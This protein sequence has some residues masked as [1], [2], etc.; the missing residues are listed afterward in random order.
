MKSRAGRAE[1]VGEAV[2]PS[3]IQA[4]ADALHGEGFA[5]WMYLDKEKLLT[6]GRG[7]LI[8]TSVAGAT[9]PMTLAWV[10]SSGNAASPDLV[11]AAINAV[12]ARPDLVPYGGAGKSPSGESFAGLT[13]VRLT[14]ATVA[15]L[16]GSSASQLASALQNYL[17]NFNAFPADAQL[18]ILRY[19]WAN[20]P[21]LPVKAPLM[22]AALG[23]RAG[24]LPDFRAAAKE[25]HW[26]NENADT[27]ALIPQLFQNAADVVDHS[28]DVSTLVWPNS[29]VQ[30]PDGVVSSTNPTTF[31]GDPI[32]WRG[33]TSYISHA[34]RFGEDILGNHT[35]A[36]VTDLTNNYGVW[37]PQLRSRFDAIKAAWAKQ[38]TS[39]WV[40][41]DAGTAASFETDLKG[42]E[43]RW[44]LAQ[45]L[46]SVDKAADWNVGILAAPLL[47]VPA[48]LE[49]FYTKVHGGTFADIVPAETVYQA[50]LSAVAQDPNHQGYTTGDYADLDRRLSAEEAT[51]GVQTPPLAVVQPHAQNIGTNVLKDTKDA[52]TPGEIAN[53]FKLV[54]AAVTAG[55]LL[56]L[57]NSAAVLRNTLKDKE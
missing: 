35:L 56:Q 53:W 20:G 50:Y 25:A 47:A 37:I 38:D 36:D 23:G 51:L 40:G 14:D 17:P 46:A 24:N 22:Y 42:L 19:A 4:F 12:K 15:S 9:D 3:V 43:Y 55:L 18:A 33:Y 52:P 21:N 10:D 26:T 32:D 1:K 16:V 41:S 13:S 49:Y 54:G 57:L 5:S 2:F 8:D 39:G 45:A 29:V 48:A 7:N 11:Q 34:P 31:S 28:L 30:T 44:A 6:T 27:A